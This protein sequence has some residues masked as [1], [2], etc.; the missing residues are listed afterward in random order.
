MDRRTIIVLL[1]SALLLVWWFKEMQHYAQKPPQGTNTVATA[2]NLISETNKVVA[3]ATATTTNDAPIIE[4][5]AP[6][7]LLTVTNADAIYTFSSHGGGVKLIA[8]KEFPEAIAC[9]RETSGERRLAT[10]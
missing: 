3:S 4:S 5:G 6:E 1:V 2:T 10:L 7:Q 8:L 9:G